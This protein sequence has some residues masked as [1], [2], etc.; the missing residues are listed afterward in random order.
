ML[1]TRHNATAAGGDSGTG[2][3]NLNGG[4]LDDPELEPDP[5]ELQD[6]TIVPFTDPRTGGTYNIIDGRVI[7]V[8]R[9]P[10][11]LPLM[12]P[13]YFDV[14]R[15][16]AEPY[17]QT[18]YTNF[19]TPAIQAFLAAEHLTEYSEWAEIAC[20]GVS[21]PPGGTV[22]DAVM[23]WPV[24]YP[25][26]IETID[27][28]A[29]VTDDFPG[30][31]G[32]P[33]DFEF[34]NQWSINEQP[35][36][37]DPIGNPNPYHIDIQ[38][39]WRQGWLGGSDVV[40]AVLDTGVDYNGLYDMRTNS[41][42]YGASTGD[43][44]SSTRITYR[45]LYGGGQPPYQSE[46]INS[47]TAEHI[48]HGTCV[49][50]ILAAGTNNDYT[51]GAPFGDELAGIS[52]SCRYFPVAMK[53]KAQSETVRGFSRSALLN[54]YA[55][56]G[57]VKRCYYGPG[58]GMNSAI[59]YYNIE[60]VNCSFGGPSQGDSEKR[61]IINLQPY[62]LFICSSGNDGANNT[63]GYPAR[64]AGLPF[65]YSGVMNVVAYDRQGNRS[66]WGDSSSNYY[67]IPNH[68]IAAP[69]T[70]IRALDLPG[71]NSLDNKL[72]YM[73]DPALI[74][75]YFRGT[76][77]AVPHVSAIAA[78]LASQAPSLTPSA[79]RTWLIFFGR[80]DLHG[81]LSSFRGLDA[82]CTLNPFHF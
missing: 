25:S 62:M 77:A 65:N 1:D 2:G 43:R 48:G 9:N 23:R 6:W 82:W 39:A 76:S 57:V 11:Q 38:Q 56:L 50:S 29:L 59:P 26:L 37:W 68:S 72:G 52:Q 67:Y 16:G 35:F 74:Y 24:Q 69:G 75:P 32:R 61:E 51:Q 73:D 14:E 8:F 18:G 21:L 13:N 81:D 70:N 41:T 71:K 5:F 40:T 17:Y 33:N 10:P 66:I 7:V 58:V 47:F 63:C 55:V 44:W 15:S 42:P 46:N 53:F 20:M 45:P 28:D 36:D 27:A 19:N 60:V 4:L 78:L 49:A 31:D 54:A 79:I 64:Y 3:N 34:M 22:L 12:D 30:G 80:T